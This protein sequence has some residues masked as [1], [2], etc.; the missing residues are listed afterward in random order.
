MTGTEEHKESSIIVEEKEIVAL[1]FLN[2]VSFFSFVKC[3][4]LNFLF[5]Y[6]MQ[7]NSVGC[8]FVGVVRDR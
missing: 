6:S 2:K 5:K 3:K 1:T 8:G 7:S 4:F